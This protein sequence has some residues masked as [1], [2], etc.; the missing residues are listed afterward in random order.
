[1]KHTEFSKSQK[2][3]TGGESHNLWSSTISSLIAQFSW[4]RLRSDSVKFQ[5]SVCSFDPIDT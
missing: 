4:K 5:W 1:M 2:R 3:K